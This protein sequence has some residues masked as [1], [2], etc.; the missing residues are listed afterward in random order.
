MFPAVS[1]FDVLLVVVFGG[2]LLSIEQV[3][4]VER[5]SSHT[6]DAVNPDIMS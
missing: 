3:V 2:G 6:S 1:L 4:N 5:Q